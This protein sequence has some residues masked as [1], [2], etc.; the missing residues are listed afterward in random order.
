MKDILLDYIK[1]KI[2]IFL[3][4]VICT[5]IYFLVFFLYYIEFEAI[6]Y[7]FILC[8]ILIIII[9]IVDFK[10]Y[11][12]KRKDLDK[13][14]ITIT[15]SLE[16]LDP[17]S[18]PTH[19]DYEEIIQILINYIK[20][21]QQQTLSNQSE[22]NDF[23]TLWV[24][25]I[26]LPISAM[27]L[28]LQSQDSSL[29]FKL[30]AELFK[31][32]Q[33]VDMVLSYLRLNSQSTDYVIK[34]YEL[35]EIIKRSIRKLSI[36]FIEK[37]L[38]LDF[39]ETKQKVLTDEKWLEYVIEQIL[40][41][42][43]K[44]TNQGCVSIYYKDDRL[45]IKDTGIGIEEEDLHRVFEKGFTGYNGRKKEESSGLGLYLCQNILTNLSHSISIKST[46]NVGTTV[47]LDL[48]HN[49]LEVE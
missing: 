36:V 14:K 18:N 46:V 9:G 25:Q 10:K 48:T 41:N 39:K 33:Y 29:N 27:N 17:S 22:I 20:N 45:F 34:E 44:Y 38:Q 31:I 16:Y 43:V 30:S 15:T 40:S 8:L 7:A 13:L 24:H 3:I 37:H 47:I 12:K 28:L 19:H 32:E 21:M 23:Y 6:I 5:F 1:E 42:A 35:D 4:L 11:Y 49:A 2:K 26:K